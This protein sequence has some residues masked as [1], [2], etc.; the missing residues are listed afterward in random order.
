M[1]IKRGFDL[2]SPCE[3]TQMA[4]SVG[5]SKGK[6]K[7]I[8]LLVL[9]IMAGIFIGLASEFNIIATF[10]TGLND[11][12]TKLLGG[13]VF[14][15][16]LILVL[17]AGAELFTGNTL[18]IISFLSRKISLK[19]LLR[20]WGIVYLGNFLGS[21]I[22]VALIVYAR[23]WIGGKEQFAYHAINIAASKVNL[24]FSTIFVRGILAN[25]LVVL[26]VWLSFS[27]RTLI[28][29]VV[30][31]IF[32]ITAFVASGFEHCIANM[33]YI[34]FGIVLKNSP[35]IITKYSVLYPEVD[36]TNLHA[37]GFVRFNLIASTLGNIVGGVCFVG[38][39]YWYVHI[40]CPRTNGKSKVNS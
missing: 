40:V 13:L 26:A 17:I 8:V 14:S 23:P 22:L 32:P 3:I 38:A 35:Q 21:L 34:P 2:L 27:G 37:L 6:E 16:G 39:L 9:G 4:A 15:L 19:E 25:M 7:G 33:F 24:D 1:A 12:L 5:V 29:K 31:V 30:A 18:L 11:S 10:D 28:D 20:N 36:L